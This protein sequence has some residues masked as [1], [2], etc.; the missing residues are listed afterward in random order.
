MLND[1]EFDQWCKR[2]NVLETAKEAIKHIRLSP[3]AR[4]VR[5]GTGNVIIHFNRSTKMAHTI[6]AESRNVEFAAILVM[7]F[8]SDVMG[9]QGENVIEIWDQPPSFII[10]YKSTKGRN[11]GHLY[12][13]DFFIIRDNSA[14]WEEWKTEEQLIKLAKKNPGRYHLA[15]DGKWHSPPCERYAEPLGLYFHVHSSKEL[16]P[17]L[18]RNAKLLLPHYRRMIDSNE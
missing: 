14:G 9:L 16:N 4:N 7:E 11:L 18:I 2:L 10:T 15:E 6:Q 5:S 12:T 8:P 13:A 3:P 1:E 17:V